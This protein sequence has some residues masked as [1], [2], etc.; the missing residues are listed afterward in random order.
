MGESKLE[1]RLRGVAG[2]KYT[3]VYGKS[4]IEKKTNKK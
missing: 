3:M 1:K 2:L 4:Q